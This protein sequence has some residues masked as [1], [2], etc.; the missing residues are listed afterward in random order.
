MLAHG[1]D[2]RWLQN[3]GIIDC[4]RGQGTFLRPKVI[5]QPLGTLYSLFR[6]VEAHGYRQRSIVRHLEERADAEAAEL[7]WT[8]AAV[9]RA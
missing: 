2:R 6:S 4:G 7:A 5:E 1:Q 9:I 8:R 3:D